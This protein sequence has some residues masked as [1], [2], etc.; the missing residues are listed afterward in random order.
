MVVMQMMLTMGQGP[1]HKG[2]EA[3]H[4]MGNFSHDARQFLAKGFVT[5]NGIV[6]LETNAKKIA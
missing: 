5:T 1:R 2:R 6:S 3:N 4:G